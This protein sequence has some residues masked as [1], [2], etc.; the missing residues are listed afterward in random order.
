[1]S[2][3]EQD[4]MQTQIAR[5]DQRVADMSKSARAQA[6]LTADLASLR[7]S[8]LAMTGQIEEFNAR[9]RLLS[10]RMARMERAMGEMSQV[11]RSE[12]L[13]R[14]ATTNLKLDALAD[15]LR[16][17]SLESR[18]FIALM[19]TK[20]G[21]P[22]KAHARKVEALKNGDGYAPPP[23]V[24]RGES[25]D[26]APDRLYQSAYEHL[27][28]REYDEAIDGFSSFLKRFPDTS[29]SDNAAYWIGESHYR[30]KEYKKAGAAFD[31]MAEKYPQSPKAAAALL[32]SAFARHASGDTAQ[33]VI[34]LR[35]VIDLYPTSDAALQANDRL[36]QLG[37]AATQP[38]PAP[39]PTPEPTPEPDTTPAA[40]GAESVEPTLAPAP[41]A[42]EEAP[43]VALDGP[44][45]SPTPVN[46]EPVDDG[47]PGPQE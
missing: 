3:Q 29:L 36:H 42:A 12:V 31:A 32:K 9:T 40:P 30:R 44:D 37:D 45:V 34:R 46:D 22:D 2:Q 26:M 24:G 35:K 14:S 27:L 28:K 17:L 18:A 5:I 38:T 15:N 1:M 39:E 7:R 23:P 11:Y 43:P 19:E 13:E 47:V 6:E 8:V 16:N 21:I 4:V 20:T 25:V 10:D 33:A 41:S